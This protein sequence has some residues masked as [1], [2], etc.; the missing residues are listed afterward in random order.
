MKRS[1][2]VLRKL[3]VLTWPLLVHLIAYS[4]AMAAISL[5]GLLAYSVAG[6]SVDGGSTAWPRVRPVFL[7]GATLFGA[8]A[9]LRWALHII[10]LRR[11]LR[12]RRISLREYSGWSARKRSAWLK[13]GVP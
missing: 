12:E 9:V 5:F 4:G 3:W 7:T 6:G 1:S 13:D 11:Q 2:S 10:E 8:L